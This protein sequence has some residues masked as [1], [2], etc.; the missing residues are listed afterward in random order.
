M[1]EFKIQ[2]D[3]LY[4]TRKGR[5]LALSCANKIQPSICC[6]RFIDLKWSAYL[7]RVVL[8]VCQIH[9][10]GE[11]DATPVATNS[12]TPR[13]FFQVEPAACGEKC[14]LGLCPRGATPEG[15]GVCA[16]WAALPRHSATRWLINCRLYKGFIHQLFI[17]R[18]LGARD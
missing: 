9:F 14:G 2:N 4:E 16:E 17:H 3:V 5:E 12:S 6:K 13:Q 8:V 15:G 11:R 1:A 18:L 7:R 10:D